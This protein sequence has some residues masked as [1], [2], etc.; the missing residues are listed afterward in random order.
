MN[1]YL[2]GNMTKE[3][4]KSSFTEGIKLGL[5]F[6]IIGIMS[7]LGFFTILVVILVIYHNDKTDSSKN[8]FSLSCLGVYI[9]S[10][11]VSLLLYFVSDNFKK[12]SSV[13]ESSEKIILL[14]SYIIGVIL[15]ISFLALDKKYIVNDSG[16]LNDTFTWLL[17]YFSISLLLSM[18]ITL[19]RII[20]F[21]K[22]LTPISHKI[23][24][25]NFIKEAKITIY[26]KKKEQCIDKK[27]FKKIKEMQIMCDLLEAKNNEQIKKLH[28]LL[29][30]QQKISAQLKFQLEEVKQET[31]KKWWFMLF[32]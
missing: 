16:A 30:Q 11:S 32:S 9:I 15:L 18:T 6:S 5:L 7:V 27:E 4:L 8:L 12:M 10:F 20:S 26:N 14:L 29:D 17:S 31:K 1:G 24:D 3:N 25:L 22:N 28:T 23:I 19:Y 21:Y 13:L 2:E